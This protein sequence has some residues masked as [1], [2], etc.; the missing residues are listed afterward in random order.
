MI[1][2]IGECDKVSSE[3]KCSHWGSED[4]RLSDIVIFY[5]MECAFCHLCFTNSGCLREC[6]NAPEKRPQGC[7]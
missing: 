2:W 4:L 7:S 1:M 5:L 6:T 3:L